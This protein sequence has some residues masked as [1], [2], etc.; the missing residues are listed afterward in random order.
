M[1]TCRLL[2]SNVMNVSTRDAKAA[3]FVW[4]AAWACAVGFYGGEVVGEGCVAEVQGAG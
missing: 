3:L 2:R 4:P 1:S